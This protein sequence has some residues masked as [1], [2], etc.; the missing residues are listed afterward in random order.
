VCAFGLVK[1]NKF[2]KVHGISNFKIEGVKPLGRPKCRGYD[3]KMG[4]KKL[5]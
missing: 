4:L 5:T 3:I 2:I 1:E